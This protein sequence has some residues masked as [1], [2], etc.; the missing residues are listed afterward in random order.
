MEV[1]AIA[2][3]AGATALGGW[4]ADRRRARDRNEKAECAAC[5]TDLQ[6]SDRSELFLIHGRLV[7]PGCADGAKRKTLLQFVGLAGA[8]A[9]ATW[10]IAASQGAVAMLALPLGSALLMTTGAVHLMKVANRRAQE[11]I[12]TGMDPSFAALASEPSFS[13]MGSAPT[14]SERTSSGHPHPSVGS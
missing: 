2:A 4:F 8:V 3:V 13:L 11:R 1:L 14:A 12:A 6:E 7:C 10:M 5:G 9:F